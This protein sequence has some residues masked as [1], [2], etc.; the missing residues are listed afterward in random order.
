VRYS[1]LG[2]KVSFAY[3]LKSI[4]NIKTLLFEGRD[5]RE[6]RRNKVPYIRAIVRTVLEKR[7][8]KAIHRIRC[9]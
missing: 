1:F 6:G 5:V 7:I 9:K 3:L 8:K 4:Q 2:F